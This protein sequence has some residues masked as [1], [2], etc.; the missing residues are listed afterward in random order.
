[1]YQIV[2][3]ERTVKVLRTCGAITSKLVGHRWRVAPVC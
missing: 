2:E 3:D 1:V